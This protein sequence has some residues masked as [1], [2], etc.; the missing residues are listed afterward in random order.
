MKPALADAIKAY[1]IA[2]NELDASGRRC[3]DLRQK[4]TACIDERAALELRLDD[5]VR[6]YNAMATSCG[7]AC[8]QLLSTV[9]DPG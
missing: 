9:M 7:A 2:R 1:R 5:E 3:D 8:E 4:I 6:A